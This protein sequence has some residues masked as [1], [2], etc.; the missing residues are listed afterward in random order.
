MFG[1]QS[2]NRLN[3]HWFVL[4]LFVVLA[5]LWLIKTWGPAPVILTNG[6]AGNVSSIVA[7]DI[8]PERF[9]NDPLFSD[10]H[11]FNFYLT[12][13]IPLTRL[14]T[15]FTHDIGQAYLLLIWPIIL[16][17]LIGFYWLGCYLFSHK[18]WAFLLSILSLS[19]VYVF[20]GELW[21][22]L[23]VPLTRSYDGAFFL[24]FY[25]LACRRLIKSLFP[26]LLMFL[27]SLSVY[28]HPVSAPSV[29]FACLT[30]L[31]MCKPD[32]RTWMKH[33]FIIFGTGL[34]FL[35]VSSP[36][37]LSFLAVSLLLPV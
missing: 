19:P 15:H 24:I 21:G 3:K 14:I 17:Q 8:H 18:G 36:F 22:Q 5:S 29:S 9:N 6:D 27:C 31:F 33:L 1:H 23:D 25:C 32:E 37:M 12:V 26:F 28:I 34:F 30:A 7:S 11:H 10:A 20:S 13:S 35:I 2:F 16:A 4:A